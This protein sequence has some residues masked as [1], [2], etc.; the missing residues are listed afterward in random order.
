MS[1]EPYFEADGVVLYHGDCREVTEWL[2]ADVL[3]TDP[4]YGRAWRRSGMPSRRGV[5]REGGGQGI[6]GD[7]DTTVRDAVLRL[8]GE[9]RTGVV[10]GDLMLGPPVG[11]KQVLVYRKPPDAGVY[12][13]MGGFRRDVEAVYLLG[14]WPHRLGGRSSVLTTA[15][16][17]QGGTAGCAG[18]NGHPHCKPLDVMAELI[19]VCPAGVVA[20]PFAGSGS[21]LVAAR[22]L[23]RKAVGVEVEERYCEQAARRLSQTVLTEECV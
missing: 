5:P 8:W 20:D 19:G 18:R 15:S 11:T 14:P 17:I 22:L 13:A 9:G 4:P 23:G 10:F 12:G 2:A 7:E 6:T 16:P 1:S 21:T 3:V